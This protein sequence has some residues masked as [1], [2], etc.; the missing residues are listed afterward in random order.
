MLLF[1]FLLFFSS[2]LV[3]RLSVL[4]SA[5]S[6]LYVFLSFLSLFN[7][8]FS[9]LPNLFCFLFCSQFCSPFCLFQC[10]FPIPALISFF[11]FIHLFFDLPCFFLA[12]NSAAKKIM[13]F[14]GQTLAKESVIFSETSLDRKIKHFVSIIYTKRLYIYKDFI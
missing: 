1:S 11:L 4:L 2:D 7:L 6:L 8:L 14:H 13:Q 12:V 5:L 10:C 9:V 3:V